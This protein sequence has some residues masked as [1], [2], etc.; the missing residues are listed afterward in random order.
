VSAHAVRQPAV[1]HISSIA[2][3]CLVRVGREHTPALLASLPAIQSLRHEAVSVRLLRV[4]GSAPKAQRLMS[5]EHAKRAAKLRETLPR[6]VRMRRLQ[7]F[8][9]LQPLRACLEAT[10]KSCIAC[11]CDAACTCAMFAT[12]RAS[13][14]G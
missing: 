7:N 13:T 5:E 14:D 8:A 1:R 4:T 12:H 2:S 3:T 6:K 11:H 9:R 10:L